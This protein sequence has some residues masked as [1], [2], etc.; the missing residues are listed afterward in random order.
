MNCSR[1]ATLIREHESR[2]ADDGSASLAMKC[3]SAVPEGEDEERSAG[4]GYRDE[5]IYT[6]LRNSFAGS[7][8]RCERYGQGVL[9][10]LRSNAVRL[11][12][13]VHVYCRFFGAWRQKELRGLH[14]I[15]CPNLIVGELFY[16]HARSDG[17]S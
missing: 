8:P 11:H 9:T 1:I 4:K 16:F 5:M 14:Q 6:V 13:V 2:C 17:V 3:C 7:R 12:M 10:D 15:F